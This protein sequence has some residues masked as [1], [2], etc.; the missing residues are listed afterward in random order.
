MAIETMMRDTHDAESADFEEPGQRLGRSRFEVL[1]N[2]GEFYLI[3]G[4]EQRCEESIAISRSRRVD[5][6]QREIGFAGA[7]RTE[8]QNP[9]ATHRN[10]GG[11]DDH[12]GHCLA[13]DSSGAVQSSGR[14]GMRTMKRA[15]STGRSLW[16]CGARP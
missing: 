8:K 13:H 14:A 3:I 1:S 2:A 15:P 11:M 12:F 10:A 16:P 4:N 6:P 5:Q 7:R 9:F